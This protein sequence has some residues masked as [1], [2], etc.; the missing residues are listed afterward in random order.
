LNNHIG[1]PLTLLAIDKE[2]TEMAVVEMGANH[3][4]EIEGYCDYVGP[5]FGIITNVGY[6]HLEGFGGFEGVVKGKTE[7]YKNLMEYDR[8]IFINA[9]NEILM[10]RMKEQAATV[11]G[12]HMSEK[13]ITYGKD[14]SYYCSGG[15]VT[16]GGFLS[17]ETEG[18]RIQTNLVGDYN[19]ENVLTAVCVGKYFNVPIE[20]IK[21]AI[22]SYVPSNNRSQKL[23]CGNNTVIMDAYNANP[24]SM[25]EALKNFERL[26]AANKV[27]I[28]GEMMELGEYAAAEHI[29]IKELTDTMNL[30]QRV[31]T[32][33][34]FNFLKDDN[35]VLYFETTE[36]LKNWFINRHF[37]DSPILIKGSRKNELEKLVKN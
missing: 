14:P 31:F 34:G 24:S 16:E 2:K 20:D 15:V 21:A 27:T 29:R 9:D 18:V 4:K 22:E 30:K 6:A 28:L 17:V 37:E 26:N 12:W 10:E 5:D 33:G 7:L 3:Q 32:G 36:Q 25:Q 13:L 23:Q 8:Y 11:R 1:I 19:F 35:S